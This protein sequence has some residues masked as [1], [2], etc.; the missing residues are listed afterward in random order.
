MASNVAKHYGQDQVDIEIVA[1]GP[2]LKLLFRENDNAARIGRLAEDTGIR[3]SAC[4]NTL[5]G[6]KK[7]TGK[8]P[9]LN[10]VSQRVVTG[11]ARIME[12]VEQ[13]YVLVRP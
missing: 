13:G 9:V 10:P 8:E 7:K 5:Q 3:F 6:I 11:V 4:N 12:L 2:G 1:F